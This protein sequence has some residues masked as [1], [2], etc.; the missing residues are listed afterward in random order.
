MIGQL[1]GSYRV[2][3]KLGEGG[4]GEVYRGVDEMLDREVA[5]KMLKPELAHRQGTLERFRAEAITLAK[6]DHPGIARIHGISRHDDLWFIVMEFVG[7]ETLHARL[8]RHGR[9]AWSEAVP[10]LCQLLDALEYAHR[11]GVV[12][13]D[14]KPANVLVDQDNR[15]KVTD[16]GIAR[17]LGTERATRTGHVVGTLEYMAPEQVRGEDVDGRSDLYAVGVLL[18]ELITGKVPFS[19]TSEYEVMMQH[20]QAPI[21]AATRVVPSLPAWF[22]GVFQRVLAK[23][24]ADRFSSAAEFQTAIE[25]LAAA[26]P[27]AVQV[28]PSRPGV[29]RPPVVPRSTDPEATVATRLAMTGATAPG[30]PSTL[31]Q[32]RLADPGAAAVPQTRLADPG[33]A[34]VP[35]TKLA[36]PPSHSPAPTVP[37]PPMPGL[38]WKV[39]TAG[40][41]L[42]L[43]LV[44][45]ASVVGWRLLRED[46]NSQQAHNDN[47]QPGPV[48]NPGPTPRPDD[49]LGGGGGP[50]PQPQPQDP[51]DL[52][53]G[54][55]AGPVR[56]NPGPKPGPSGPAKPGGD[57][58][59]PVT[60]G[61]S[62]AQPG[63]NDVAPPGPAGGGNVE[64]PAETKSEEP[65]EEAEA[66]EEEAKEAKASHEAGAIEFEEVMLRGANGAEVEVMLFFES[67]RLVV[68]DP[69]NEKVVRSLPYGTI[70]E[71]TYTRGRRSGLMR[72]ASHWLEIQAGGA[73]MVFKVDGGEV[74]KMVS[75]LEVRGHVKVRRVTSE[76]Q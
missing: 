67:K 33:A 16:F 21:P 28:N 20:L 55:V 24:R 65:K 1:L 4:M 22:D 53:G 6:L 13:R 62:P 26:E 14:L 58:A 60:P 76:Q 50:A 66:K 42:V 36:T 39:V 43:V 73:Q 54:G 44:A 19:G 31:P 41:A 5:L 3:E 32:T 23:V 8:R 40:A 7:G 34:G 30:G 46:P 11:R 48:P 25:M 38:S 70:G 35:P 12:H 68:T 63:G 37:A 56:P 64:K 47:G 72:R 29:P 49:G 52:G 59:G 69:D 10:I 17:V 75:A 61:P 2:V 74:E 45:V 18:F 27:M 57:A 71:A 15:V 51:I 9:L